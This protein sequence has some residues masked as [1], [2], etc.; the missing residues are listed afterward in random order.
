MGSR[1]SLVHEPLVTYISNTLKCNLTSKMDEIS[2]FKLSNYTNGLKI[3]YMIPDQP[4][5]LREFKLI[6]INNEYTPQTY[7]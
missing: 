5:T 7:M 2:K 3:T 6:G 4:H 1:V